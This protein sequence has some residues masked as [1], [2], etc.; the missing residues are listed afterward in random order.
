MGVLDE[1]SREDIQNGVE[2]Q[3][4]EGCKIHNLLVVGK[5]E[6]EHNAKETSQTEYPSV[7]SLCS[8]WFLAAELVELLGRNDAVS[9]S[10]AIRSR[11]CFSGDAGSRRRR[12]ASHQ[13]GDPPP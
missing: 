11:T 2:V 9:L 5:Q 12:V 13:I 1:A 3:V 6:S 7:S 4:L 8:F 10:F